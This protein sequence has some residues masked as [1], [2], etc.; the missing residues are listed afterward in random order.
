MC[1]GVHLRRAEMV[2]D[3]ATVAETRGL[4]NVLDVFGDAIFLPAIQDVRHL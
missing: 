3:T 4:Y 2:D 1:T